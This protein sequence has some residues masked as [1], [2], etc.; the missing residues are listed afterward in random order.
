VTTVP[1]HAIDAMLEPLAGTRVPGGCDDCN[2][3][4]T[5]EQVDAG[6]WIIDARCPLLRAHA[7]A[8]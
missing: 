5:V 3:H 8:R 4:Q 1:Q 6:A 7:G 2:A